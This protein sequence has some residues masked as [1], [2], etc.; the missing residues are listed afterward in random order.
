[1]PRF[2]CPTATAVMMALRAHPTIPSNLMPEQA[3]ESDTGVPHASLSSDPTLSVC[4]WITTHSIL[5]TFASNQLE[6]GYDILYYT[7][8]SLEAAWTR[9][10]PDQ[11]ITKTIYVQPTRQI[12][13][14]LLPKPH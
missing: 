8:F 4:Y 7:P 14:Q 9:V 2:L 6:A 13:K 5:Q 1:M 12:L 10:H 11:A 3:F